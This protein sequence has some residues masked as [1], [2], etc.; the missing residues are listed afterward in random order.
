MKFEVKFF[1]VF[2]KAEAIQKCFQESLDK[3]L[4]EHS[5]CIINYSEDLIQACFMHHVELDR[6]CEEIISKGIQFNE[7]KFYSP[8]FV[9]VENYKGKSWEAGW[10]ILTDGYCSYLK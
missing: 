10:L 4:Q 1:S 3:F 9:V 7:D 6:F 2:I 5:G 8:D